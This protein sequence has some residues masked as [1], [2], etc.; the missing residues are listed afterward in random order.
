MIECTRIITTEI[1]LISKL[2]SE[3][4]LLPKEVVSKRI[5]K[6]IKSHL[7]A[8]SVVITKVQDFIVDKDENKGKVEEGE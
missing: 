2:E 5:K 1:I 7:N 8:D 6:S 4:Q 3:E